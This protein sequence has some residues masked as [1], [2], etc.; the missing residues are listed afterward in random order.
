MTLRHPV[1]DI[2]IFYSPLHL[3]R[4]ISSFSNLNH[5]SRSLGLFCKVSLKR[6]PRD[7][8]WRLSLKD[9]P[10]AMWLRIKS[11]RMSARARAR[12]RALFGLPCRW[13][14]AS[15]G[16]SVLQC[17]AVCAIGHSI[18]MVCGAFASRIICLS[19][20]ALITLSLCALVSLPL[21]RCCS[22]FPRAAACCSMFQRV[23]ACSSMLQ[24]A[25]AL[26]SV[27]QRWQCLDIISDISQNHVFQFLSTMVSRWSTI[28]QCPMTVS[29]E[30]AT[31]PKSTTSSNSD[32]SVLARY[33]FRL[34]SWFH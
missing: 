3:E 16:C 20:F 7:W 26:C 14:G 28:S 33:K 9:T 5:W 6:D 1:F 2:E 29:T 24:R 31:P 34:K 12:A 4:V 17:G 11:I 13:S 23:P 8:D 21:V 18:L 15:E 19:L 27:E 10:N 32:S 22:V 25:A 30:F